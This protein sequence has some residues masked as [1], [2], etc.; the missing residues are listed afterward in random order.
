MAPRRRTIV[1][2]TAAVLLG[3]VALGVSAVVVVTQTDRGR[4]MIMRAMVPTLRAAVPGYLYVGRVGG[5]LFT[6]ITI[7]SLEIREPNGRPF[8][9][10]G[11]I[12][13]TYDPRDLLDRRIV[14]KSLD[15]QRPRLTVVDYGADDWNWKRALLRGGPSRPRRRGD[16]G[17]YVVLDTATLHD[18]NL[19]VRQ[20][21]TLSDTLKGAKRDSALH[22]NLTRLDGEVR[23][24]GDKYFR[25]WRFTRGDLALGRSRIADPDSAGARLALQKL[26]VIWV[27]PPFWFRNMRGTVRQ[28][29]DS[30][31]MDGAQFQLAK[32]SGRGDAKIVWGSGLPVR[33]DIR[34]QGDTVAMSDV[35]WIDET[36]P[37]TGGGST[38]LTIKNDPKNLSVIEYQ[39]RNMD[40]RSMRSRL[41]GRMT[42]GVGGPV[43]RVTDVALDLKPANTDLLRQFNQ[44]PFPYDWQ[45]DLSGRVVA[46]G[47][48]VT[49]FQLDQAT[50]T[51]DDAHVPGAQSRGAVTGMLN[52]FTPSEAILKGV[53]LRIDQLDLRTP[54]FVNP[55][56]V[57]LNGIVRGTMRLDSLW[58]DAHFTDADLEHV[59]GPGLPSH[60]TGRGNYTLLPEGV[61]FDVEM[62]AAPLSY[63]TMSRSYPTMPLRGSAVGSIR[64]SGM[65]EDFS[66]QMTLAGEGGEIAYN[67]RAD[68]FEP[69]FSATGQFRVQSANLQAL[70][71]DSRFP[72]SNLSL[73]GDID[74]RGADLASMRGP[75][76]AT[77]DQ[78]SRI[79]DVRVFGGTAHATFDSGLVRVDTMTVESSAFRLTAR[80]GL[81]LVAGRSDSL[82][83]AA[84]VDSLGGLR[85]WLQSGDSLRRLVNP[86]DTLRG[87]IEVRGRLTGT[88]DTLDARGLT[89]DARADANGVAFGTARAERANA[90]LAVRDVMH[91]GDGLVQFTMDSA[92]AAGIDIAAAAGRSTVRRGLA[93]RFAA[94]FRT[95]SESRV[96]MTGGVARLQDTTTVTIDTLSIRVDSGSA[97]ARGFALA[98]PAVVQVM[99]NRTGTLD[100]LVLVHTDTGR[101]ALRGA[102]GDSGAVRGRFDLDRLPLADVGRLLASSALAGGTA[103]GS[104]SIAGT[105]ERPVFDARLTLRDALMGRMRL[106]ALDA[107]A[108]YDSLRLGV[109]AALVVDG[110]QALTAEASLPLDLALVPGRVRQRDESLTG[111]IV[112][113]RADL[114][115]LESLFPDVTS[116]RGRFST[117][118]RLTG[119]W[120]RPRLRGQVS[121]DSAAL[122]LENLGIRLEQATADIGL[123]GDTVFIRRFGAS[124]GAPAD[125]LGISGTISLVEPRTPRFDLRLT[126]NNFLAIDKAR[127]A[128]LV[129]TTTSPITL[130]GSQDAARVRGAVRIDRGKVYIRALAQRRGLDLTDNFDVIDTTFLGFNALLPKAPNA[131][132]QN[133]E[134][135]NVRLNIG[136]DV[137]LRSPEA[138]LKLGGSLRVTRSLGR[139]DRR[140][141]L[142]LSDSLV[143][144]RGTYQLNLGIARPSFEV[145]RGVV[146]FYGDA[147][148]QPALDITALH[149]VR[150]LRANSNRQDVRIRVS[151]GGTLDRPTLALSSADNPPLPES[152]MLSYLVT[153]EPAYALLGSAYAEQG[154]TL[155]LRFAGSFLSSRLAGGRFD[156][157]Q[158]EPTALGPGDAANLRANVGGIL[159]STRVGVGGQLARNTYFAFTTGLCGLSAQTSGG[160]DAL[161]LFAQG[162]GV[163]VERRFDRGFSASL[164]LEPASSAQACGRLGI[165]RTFQQTPPQVGVDFFRAWTF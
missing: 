152:D 90:S 115:L 142:A 34:I 61:R 127:T 128:S 11:P 12:R 49:D 69:V 132:V 113:N 161:S 68:G 136:D 159:A 95:I 30:L 133:L 114:A 20:P 101:L 67:G 120:E 70:F 144:D 155:A 47:G 112:S 58:Y 158:V 3:I 82:Q 117:D 110:R 109:D 36:L 75:V 141:Q 56:F 41:T 50:F 118:V 84:A 124:S 72:R 22:Y 83:F 134:L 7:D 53:D 64:A 46:R 27:Y 25:V 74:M 131:L 102:I 55:L 85:P 143:V 163:K 126:A 103:S 65:A 135:D 60:V 129:L 38:E 78:F 8:V 88:L 108:R 156:V 62:Q 1:L 81:G 21:W 42:F 24:D 28:L 79:A 137:W 111:R 86:S 91:G 80:G 151:I 165:S 154:A 13:V 77:V 146:R 87:T 125:S 45:G 51:F 52:I 148:L 18:V 76:R 153:G 10:T 164:G 54:R 6:D 71:G 31:W 149:T 33:Y 4:A 37:R 121:M 35:A 5:T 105:R 147:D 93:E 32:S 104:A 150:E 26:D 15:V 40:A 59:D 2:A 157:V 16:F 66:L 139:D 99:P 123:A 97:R 94:E 57:E 89:L 100:S 96:A 14:I 138:N 140:A 162:L 9:A 63:T 17:D 44:E 106:G 107:T 119:S 160:G 39:L 122:T 19:V 73:V 48:P 23:Q 98:A 116:A 29:G 92:R 130:V 43:L 145:E